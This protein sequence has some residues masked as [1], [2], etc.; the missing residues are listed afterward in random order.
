MRIEFAAGTHIAD[1]ARDLVDAARRLGHVGGIFN[2]IELTADASTT[3][4]AVVAEFE[5]ESAAKAETY[6]NS[7]EGQAAQKASDERRADMQAKH[8]R[9]MNRLPDLDWSNDAA[10]LEWLCEMQAP[11][12]HVGVTVL[13]DTIATEFEQRGFHAGVNT[14]ADYKPND[15]DN[16]FRYLVGQALDGLKSG[17]AIHPILHRFSAEW[18]ERFGIPSTQ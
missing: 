4:E 10:V 11:S 7:P 6:R 8:D 12:D 15:R 18:R 2:G 5:R 17:P 1:A 3:P 13:S 14:G 16:A 9:L